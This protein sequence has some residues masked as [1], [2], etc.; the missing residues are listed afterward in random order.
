LIFESTMTGDFPP[1]SKITGVRCFAAA[2]IT[3][4]PTLPLPT[5]L[6]GIRWTAVKET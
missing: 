1:S 2:V 5:Q 3:M 6:Q 4:R